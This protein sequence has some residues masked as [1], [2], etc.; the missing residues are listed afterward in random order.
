M[1]DAVVSVR[2][3]EVLANLTVQVP[4]ASRAPFLDG[5]LS[6]VAGKGF[7]LGSWLPADRPVSFRDTVFLEAVKETERISIVNPFD[8]EE[9]TVTVASRLPQPQG[10][11]VVDRLLEEVSA[12]LR[13]R[14]FNV[15]R[16]KAG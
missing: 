10:N 8:P 3:E 5:L 4:S 6:F 1:S 15:A 7:R 2:A 11:E 16:E 12:E 13:R 9:F 14:G